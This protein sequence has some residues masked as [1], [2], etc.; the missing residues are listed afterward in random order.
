ME[1]IEA[2]KTDFYRSFYDIIRVNQLKS[3][4]PVGH[5]Q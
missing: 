3:V 4:S 1:L 5:S 2:I